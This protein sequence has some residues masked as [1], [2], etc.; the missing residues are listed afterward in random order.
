M[1]AF[2]Q[3]QQLEAEEGA[4]AEGVA[5]VAAEDDCQPARLFHLCMTPSKLQDYAWRCKA[6]S[7]CAVH[8]AQPHFPLTEHECWSIVVS[9][10]CWFRHLPEL[11]LS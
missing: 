3:L 5:E 9:Q 4:E 7:A 6:A 2:V 1:F 11:L 8:V 10:N